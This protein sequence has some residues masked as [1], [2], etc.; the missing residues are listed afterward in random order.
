[1][2]RYE[3]IDRLQKQF[4]FTD[5]D[6]LLFS[7]LAEKGFCINNDFNLIMVAKILAEKGIFSVILPAPKNQKEKRCKE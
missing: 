6:K 7:N 1:V 2:G 4:G 5:A 3:Y